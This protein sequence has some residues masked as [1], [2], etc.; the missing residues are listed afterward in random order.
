MSRTRKGVQRK[1]L[2]KNILQKNAVLKPRTLV[3]KYYR[4]NFKR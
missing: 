4:M 3:T 2:K 1:R